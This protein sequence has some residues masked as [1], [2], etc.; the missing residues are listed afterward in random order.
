M[1]ARQ[2]RRVLPST[3]LTGPLLGQDARQVSQHIS[4]MAHVLW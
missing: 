4:Q 2:L 1:T 3:Q